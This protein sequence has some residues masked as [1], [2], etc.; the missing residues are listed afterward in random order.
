MNALSLRMTEVMQELGLDTQRDLAAFCGVTDSLVAQWFAGLTGLGPKPLR[1]FARKT[2]Y[3][4]DWLARGDLPKRRPTKAEAARLQ[5]AQADL[6]DGPG[7]DR[8]NVV[9]P[10]IGAL[11]GD[12]AAPENSTWEAPIIGWAAVL[13]QGRQVAAPN[14]GTVPVPRW[15]SRKAYGLR[16]RDTAMMGKDDHRSYPIGSIVIVDP[17]KLVPK[18]GRRVI[19]QIGTA[20]EIVLREYVEEFGMRWLRAYSANYGP[21]SEPFKILGTVIG[22]VRE[23]EDT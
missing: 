2:D 13:E 15:A 10:E 16:V 22:M 12:G 1:A 23:E 9:A 8:S 20:G 19:A 17:M 14:E 3:N 21:L 11:S 7:P 5:M 6:A 18:T 4:L